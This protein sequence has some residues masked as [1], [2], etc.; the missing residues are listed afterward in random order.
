MR[1]EG[2]FYGAFRYE[3]NGICAVTHVLKYTS[4]DTFVRQESF[5]GI[6]EVMLPSSG[7]VSPDANL[8]RQLYLAKQYMT[9]SGNA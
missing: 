8:S 2:R 5:P 7:K 1:P 3:D 6:A 9:A 4:L